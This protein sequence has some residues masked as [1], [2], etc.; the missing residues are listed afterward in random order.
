MATYTLYSESAERAKV[1]QVAANAAGVQLTVSTVADADSHPVVEHASI[2][3]LPL[4]S[5]PRGEIANTNAIL[6]YIANVTDAP[7]LG[8][9]IFGECE[10]SQW[11]EWTLVSLA[12]LLAALSDSKLADAAKGEL[13]PKLAPLLAYVEAHL[14]SRTWLVG[15]RMSIA[16][17]SLASTLVPAWDGPAAVVAGKETLPNVSRWLLT[18][19][20]QSSFTAVFGAAP[21][22]APAAPAFSVPSAGSAS[23]SAPASAA[24][25]TAGGALTPAAAAEIA[26]SGLALIGTGIDTRIAGLYNRRRARVAEV[27]TAGETLIGQTITV[28]GWAK[29]SRE[30]G[31]GS[32]N[33]IA[34]TDGS[35]FEVI[36]V[37]AEKG[38]TAGFETLATAG[39]THASL[40]VVGQVVKSP[41]K[42]QAIEILATELTVLGSV[43]NAA[44]Y[45]LAKKKHSIEYL[46]E[47]MHLRPRTNTVGA[48]TRVRNACAFA[49]HKFFQ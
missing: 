15:E 41:A 46:R 45:P 7:L 29:T 33:F 5:T 1:F 36:Q 40:K 25:T 28:C 12:P 43:M 17:V 24:A 10:V 8:S 2:P 20:N 27:L 9:G 47:I 4:L 34:L 6:K 42:G 21:G 35:C 14:S 3:S 38:K 32:L 26:L 49:T 16:D 23:S 13:K 11:L 31:A 44:E 30:G 37:V 22:P 19:R 39:G 48:V 18:C